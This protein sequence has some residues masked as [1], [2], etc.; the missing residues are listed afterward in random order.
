MKNSNQVELSIVIPAFNEKDVLPDAL[1]EISNVVEN[2]VE[3]YEIIV[4]D[5]GST[6]G[7]F[8]ILVDANAKK[9]EI[10]AIRLSRQFG[11]E[12][13][14]LAG[15]QHASGKAVITIDADLQHPPNVIPEML[16][17]WRKGAQIVHGVKR[18]R[19]VDSPARRMLARIYNGIFSRIAGF[20]LRGSSDYKLL[21]RR[22]V[23]LLKGSFP[24]RG[25]FYRGLS[26]W[27]GYKQVSV[28][29]DVAERDK[30]QSHWGG[31]P[32]IR[33]AV[34]TLTAFSS[35][36]LIIVPVLGL[37]MLIVAV[38]LG[39]EAFV[40]KL[41]GESVSGFATLEITMLF[42]GSM[43]MIGLGIIGHYLGRM[44]DEVKQRP[45]YLTAEL[46]GLDNNRE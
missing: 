25:R 7:S 8:D 33:Y 32:L 6:D 17:H 21:D 12:A 46:V 1:K 14:L 15:L 30:G 22:I 13:A 37:V 34:R 31:I 4:V 41:A 43:I 29:F 19:S 3:D 26:S 28:F 2:L 35:L 5:D 42:T 18:D 27:V 38:V 10:R 20:D 24:E 23:D 45:E 36:P 16:E 39:V 11:K 40:S 44:F 9:P